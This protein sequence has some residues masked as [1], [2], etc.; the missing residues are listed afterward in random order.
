MFNGLSFRTTIYDIFGYLMPGFLLISLCRIISQIHSGATFPMLT[1][2][3]NVIG[4]FEHLVLSYVLGHAVNALSKIVYE[5][6]LFAKQ[7][8]NAKN[9]QARVTDETRRK[10][11]ETRTKTL[12]NLSLSELS[13]KELRIRC[14]EKLPQAY[15]TGFT[16]LSFY[17]MSRSLALL[18]LPLL[19]I[20]VYTTW[21]WCY[22]VECKCVRSV[23]ALLGGSL[24]LGLAYLFKYQY[25]RFVELYYDYLGASL[26][27]DIENNTK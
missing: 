25:L 19:P 24:A 22:F 2:P 20:L 21:H 13:D 23:L 5:K 26:L 27:V 6:G 10:N 18:C 1:L 12:F 15:S 16:Y 9:W 17:G 3:S 4:A 11:L 7:F 8:Q 14:E